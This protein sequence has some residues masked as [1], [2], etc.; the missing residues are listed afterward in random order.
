ML[1]VYSAAR[2]CSCIKS[3]QFSLNSEINTKRTWMATVTATCVLPCIGIP[4]CDPLG[5]I[6][7]F[8]CDDVKF[9]RAWPFV[10]PVAFGTT[11]GN[12]HVC[13]RPCSRVHP[14]RP[15]FILVRFTD[16]LFCKLPA[17]HRASVQ[18]VCRTL[19]GPS[20]PEQTWQMTSQ[21]M[22]TSD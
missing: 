12:S 15:V 14:Q 2:P 18:S 8:C 5:R 20:R 7:G 16:C 3:H 21:R 22:K 17:Y 19:P 9:M 13:N 11:V 1:I 6:Y 10:P 4:V